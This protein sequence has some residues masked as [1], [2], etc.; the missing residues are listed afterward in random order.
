MPPI[1]NVPEEGNFPYI[2]SRRKRG[3]KYRRPYVR[4]V[5]GTI[6]NCLQK[7]YGN[8]DIQLIDICGCSRTDKGVHARNMIISFNAGNKSLPFDGDL[9]KLVYVLNRMLPFDIRVQNVCYE[10]V[11]GFHP[12]IDAISKTYTYHFSIGQSPDPLRWRHELQIEGRHQFDIKRAKAVAKLMK[13]TFDFSAFRGAFRGNE[14]GKVKDPT[15]TIF[16]IEID[17]AILSELNLTTPPHPDKLVGGH[18]A[19]VSYVIKIR[20]NRF[21]YKMVRFL[22]GTLISAGL[23]DITENEVKYALDNGQWERNLTN[24]ISCAPAN[25]LILTQVEYDENIPFQW[26]Y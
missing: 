17:Y 4:S 24:N 1:H 6:K 23:G 5:E 26:V 10:P 7:L 13:G 11:S 3:K 8:I 12:T 20:G 2:S 9:Q 22:S 19:S 14:R 15:C 18:M 25:G 16:E 21:L